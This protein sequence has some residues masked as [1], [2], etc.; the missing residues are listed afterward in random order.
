MSSA[1]TLYVE[2]IGVR[3]TGDEQEGAVATA[4]DGSAKGGR[5]DA[6]KGSGKEMG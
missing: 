1:A 4:S 3:G 2:G 5:G 6:A